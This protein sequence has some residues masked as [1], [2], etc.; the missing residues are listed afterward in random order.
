MRVRTYF[1]GNVSEWCQSG[2]RVTRLDAILMLTHSCPQTRLQEGPCKEELHFIVPKQRLRYLIFPRCEHICHEDVIRT[3][4][5]TE[6][7]LA[8][9]QVDVVQ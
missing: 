3:V 7:F 8:Y 5:K 2:E 4:M 6:S 9:V 1:F